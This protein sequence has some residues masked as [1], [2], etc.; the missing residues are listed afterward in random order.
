MVAFWQR[1][2]VGRRRRRRRPAV[3]LFQARA[4]T[5]QNPATRTTPKHT[6]KK[7]R[8]ARVC[9]HARPRRRGQQELPAQ[10]PRLDLCRLCRRRL[11][12]AGRAERRDVDDQGG[13]RGRRRA[14]LRLRHRLAG[15]IQTRCCCCCCCCCAAV[16]DEAVCCVRCVSHNNATPAAAANNTHNR[17]TKKQT[18]HPMCK[19]KRRSSATSARS[20]SRAARS[21][22]SLCARPPRCALGWF[23]CVCVHVCVCAGGVLLLFWPRGSAV[24]HLAHTNHHLTNTNN[25]QTKGV[26]ARR[27]AAAPHHRDLPPA[28]DSSVGGGLFLFR[29]N[30]DRPCCGG[31]GSGAVARQTSFFWGGGGERKNHH[32]GF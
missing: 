21:L 27:A 30:F 3:L 1:A 22:R 28:V 15:K 5:P 16:V 2:V 26:W 10:R 14:V 23:F 31:G 24:L 29:R 8:P 4:L 7:P 9:H 6:P 25:K 20:P 17:T 13:A 32:R 19:N 11:Q 12:P 18:P